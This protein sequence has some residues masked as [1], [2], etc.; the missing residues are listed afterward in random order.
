MDSSSAICTAKGF[1]FPP[2]LFAPDGRIR[3][4]NT[5]CPKKH[6][7]IPDENSDC[8]RGL[9]YCPRTRTLLIQLNTN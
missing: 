8:K 6:I 3:E 9:F 7:C 5:P 4:N 2:P 1:N